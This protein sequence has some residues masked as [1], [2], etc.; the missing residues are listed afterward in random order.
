MRKLINGMSIDNIGTRKQTDGAKLAEHLATE[1]SH[2][3]KLLNCLS[4]M[5]QA[6][7][8]VDNFLIFTNEFNLRNMPKTGEW[9]SNWSSCLHME[10]IH[11]HFT[12]DYVLHLLQSKEE[13]AVGGELSDNSFREQKHLKRAHFDQQQL[14]T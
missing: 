10:I 5:A 6:L 9:N 1:L 4:N 11:N 7:K 12:A 2:F 14:Q 3:E 13:I 8:N